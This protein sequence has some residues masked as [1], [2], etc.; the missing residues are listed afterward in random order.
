MKRCERKTGNV[1]LH[2][3]RK[4]HVVVPPHSCSAAKSLIWFCLPGS[5]GLAIMTSD[6]SGG[7]GGDGGHGGHGGHDGHIGHAGHESWSWWT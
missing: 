6:Y 5:L 7:D 4:F 2:P 1:F 3:Y